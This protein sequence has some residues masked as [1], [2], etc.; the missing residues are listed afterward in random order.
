MNNIIN[1]DYE[2]DEIKQKLEVLFKKLDLA[3]PDGILI[4]A[5]GLVEFR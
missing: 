1:K 2:D 4:T 3:Y 5:L